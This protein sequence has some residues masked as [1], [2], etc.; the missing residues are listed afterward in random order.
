MAYETVE[1]NRRLPLLE[2][3]S[4]IAGRMACRWAAYFG[5]TL[6]GSGVLLGGVPGVPAGGGRRASAAAWPARTRRAWRMGL[7]RGR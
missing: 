5:E 6:G 4:E 2:P 1:L 7:E 3:M